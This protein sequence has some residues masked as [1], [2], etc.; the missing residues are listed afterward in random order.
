MVA[1]AP[2]TLPTALAPLAGF[3]LG[4][5]AF[6]CWSRAREAATDARLQRRLW[7]HSKYQRDFEQASPLEVAEWFEGQRRKF[8]ALACLCGV[9]A[10]LCV[11]YAAYALAGK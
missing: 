7:D 5:L 1:V 11:G 3:F 10:L 6:W 9:L 8:T 2:A 4:L